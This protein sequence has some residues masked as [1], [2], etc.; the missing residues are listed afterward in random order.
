MTV[1]NSE[2]QL[3]FPEFEQEIKH[4]IEYDNHF[5]SLINQYHQLNQEIM[6]YQQGMDANCETSAS[7]LAKKLREQVKLIANLRF[8]LKKVNMPA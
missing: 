2:L 7:Y 8:M 6:L 1:S 4:L 3:E 5:H